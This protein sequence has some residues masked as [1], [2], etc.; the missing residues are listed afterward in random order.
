MS[1]SPD[2]RLNT[3][4]HECELSFHNYDFW[5]KNMFLPLLLCSLKGGNN[6]VSTSYN[7]NTRT[8]G[9]KNSEDGVRISLKLHLGSWLS[10]DANHQARVVDA[11]SMPQGFQ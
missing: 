1:F 3:L 6:L 7:L 11:V 2:A 4:Y 9:H 10:K 5:R 8:L